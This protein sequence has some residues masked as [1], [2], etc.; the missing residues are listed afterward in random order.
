MTGNAL[1]M[2]TDIKWD[3]QNKEANVGLVSCGDKQFDS[4]RSEH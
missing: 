4:C 2:A 1:W 3:F